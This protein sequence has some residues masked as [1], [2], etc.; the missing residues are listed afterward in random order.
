[1]SYHVPRKC[2]LSKE[3]LQHFQESQTHK[4][5]VSY[6]ET[7]NNALIGSKLTDECSMSPVSII[8]FTGF[9]KKHMNY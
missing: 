5:I 6:I 7:L 2:I 9:G 1:M 8:L 3:Q 4:D